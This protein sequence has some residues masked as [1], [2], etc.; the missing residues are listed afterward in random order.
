MTTGWFGTRLRRCRNAG[1]PIELRVHIGG[2]VS[3][4]VRANEDDPRLLTRERHDGA[5][6]PSQ[7]L[8]A[9]T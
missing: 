5:I 1:K 3:V 2:P 6:R 4:Q 9:Q 7:V 8:H